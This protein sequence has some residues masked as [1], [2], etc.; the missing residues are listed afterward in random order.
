[1]P[2]AGWDISA[3]T[4]DQVRAAV[5]RALRQMQEQKSKSGVAWNE[6]VAREVL[7]DVTPHLLRELRRA[8]D[9]GG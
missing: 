1:M 6:H 4:V 9:N 2:N 8:G 3:M 5:D 7:N